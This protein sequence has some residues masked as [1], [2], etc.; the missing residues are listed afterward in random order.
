[1]FKSVTKIS[2]SVEIA[3]YGILLLY[4]GFAPRKNRSGAG[5]IVNHADVASLVRW[6]QNPLCRRH[7]SQRVASTRDAVLTVGRS[8]RSGVGGI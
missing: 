1:V 3:T 4:G 8:Q 5:G 7:S 6:V 2:L